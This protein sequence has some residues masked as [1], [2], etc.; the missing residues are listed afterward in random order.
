MPSAIKIKMSQN[1]LLKRLKKR[2]VSITILN[3]FTKLKLVLSKYTNICLAFTSNM[4]HKKYHSL[5][6]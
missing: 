6:V 2:I 5:N 3:I 4:C 1:N